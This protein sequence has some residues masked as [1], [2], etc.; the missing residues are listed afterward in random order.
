MSEIEQRAERVLARVPGWIW[1]G[2]SLPVPVEDIADSVFRLRVR[3]VED[4][5]SAPGAPALE[6]GSSL[7]G[8]LLPGRGEIWVNGPEAR[9]WPPRRRFT[10]GHELGHWCMH[11]TD[12]VASIYCRSASVDPREE[13]PER[14][15][16]EQEADAFAAALLMPARLLREH[17]R[18]NRDFHHLC[19]L[20]GASGASM[21]R[22]LHAVI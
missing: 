18:R 5:T 17:Y 1:D 2:D 11:R 3:E 20:F 12:H 21:G 4:L 15:L 13:R 16:A 9:E 19:R 7:S 8:L 14:P 10:I 6:P 22:R